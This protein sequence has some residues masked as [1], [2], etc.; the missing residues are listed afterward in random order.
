MT[1]AALLVVMGVLCAVLLLH[2]PRRQSPS[3][4]AR[5]RVEM[6]SEHEA[7]LLE[8][9]RETRTELEVE[10]AKAARLAGGSR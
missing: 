4:R 2:L 5:A 10:R 9:L 7:D 6:L 1:T 3:E 8:E